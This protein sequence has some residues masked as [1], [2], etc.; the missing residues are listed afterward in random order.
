MDNQYFRVQIERRLRA[1]MKIASMN[2]GL[3]LRE[4]TTIAI[5]KALNKKGN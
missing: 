5:E 2:C 3:Q 4:W 1:K